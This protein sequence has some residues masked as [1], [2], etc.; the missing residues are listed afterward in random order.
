[1][2][3]ILASSSPRRKEL[4]KLIFSEF[5]I[6]PSDITEDIPLD[7]DCEHTAEYLASKKANSIVRNP[8]DL[9]IGCDTVVVSDNRILGKPSDHD[10]CREMLRQLSGKTHSVYTG[11]FIIVNDTEVS[12]TE[13]TNVT[14]LEISDDE[15]EKYIIT[16]EPFDKA[17]GYGIQGKGALFVESIKGDYFNV[18]GLPVARL[19]Y[20]LKKIL[21][22]VDK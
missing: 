7:I 15:I 2:N 19:N 22:K 11:V 17:G 10:E 14:F 21:Y 4:M 12:F 8:D 16:G 18:V 1:M 5:L 13:K 3:I 9:V 6:R 20:E